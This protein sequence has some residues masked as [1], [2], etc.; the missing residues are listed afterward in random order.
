[1]VV[2][3]KDLLRTSRLEDLLSPFTGNST[4][5]FVLQPGIVNL[6]DM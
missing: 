1:M 5:S 6:G 4:F 2:L 3:L